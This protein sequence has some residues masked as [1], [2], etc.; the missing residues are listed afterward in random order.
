[1]TNKLLGSK[2]AT[3]YAE[4]LFQLGIYLYLKEKDSNLFYQI[5]FDIQDLLK[6]FTDV[7]SFKEF[8]LNPLIPSKDKKNIL[9]KCLNEESNILDFLQLLIDKKRIQYIDI[10]TSQ[11]LEKIYNYLNIKFVEVWSVVRLNQDQQNAIQGKIQK[12]L[13]TIMSESD[14]NSAKIKLILRLDPSLLGGLIIKLDSK[15][16]D[17]S[18]KGELQFFAKKLDIVI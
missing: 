3:P 15:I 18:F 17:L 2:I 4:A 1:M 12:L 14:A 10:I 7:P 9:K 6:L 13:K 5:I 8:L 11:F 16:I